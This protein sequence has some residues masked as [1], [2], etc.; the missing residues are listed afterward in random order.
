MTMVRKSN[1]KPLLSKRGFSSR[2][3]TE[4]LI[5]LIK[6]SPLDQ[7]KNEGIAKIF[8]AAACELSEGGKGGLTDGEILWRAYRVLGVKSTYSILAHWCSENNKPKPFKQHI[9]A[10]FSYYGVDEL[11]VKIDSKGFYAEF[12]QAFARLKISKGQMLTWKFW[13]KIKPED[14]R[15]LV[16]IVAGSLDKDSETFNERCFYLP[17]DILDGNDLSS[18]PRFYWQTTD[19]ANEQTVRERMNMELGL[20]LKGVFK[21]DFWL[22]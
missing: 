20:N 16:E 15:R 8:T 22:P 4:F 3:K 5:H 21:K 18:L 19:N 6:K 9:P 17:M 7:F 2:A 13:E 10:M 1:C 14:K 12:A 11:L